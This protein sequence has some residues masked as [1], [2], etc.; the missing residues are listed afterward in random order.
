MSLEFVSLEKIEEIA[1]Q[2]GYWAVFGGILLENL[3]IPLPGETVTLIGGF[4]A[5][6]GQLNYWFVLGSA[7][8]GAVI[9]GTCGYWIG[10]FAGWPFL[11]KLSSLLRIPEHR[12]EESKTKFSE[13]AAKA[14][15]FGRF[16]A[17]LRVLAGLLA[18]IAEMPFGKFFLYNL[19]GAV[20]WASVMVTLSFFLGQFVSLEELVGLAGQFTIVALIIVVAW[21]VVPLW[22]E[23]R[24]VKQSVAKPEE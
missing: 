10:R 21:I 6:S 7:I 3:G 11:V 12:V 19:A 16:I 18:G 8:L 4:L 20:V 1:Q 2:Y 13:N 23:S 17:L 15:F 9:G 24:Q 22:L 14:V 5:G